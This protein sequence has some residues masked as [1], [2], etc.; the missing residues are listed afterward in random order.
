MGNMPRSTWALEISMTH[1]DNHI[2]ST[3]CSS[4]IPSASAWALS[5][6]AD[7]SCQSEEC[8][9]RSSATTSIASCT[10][11][12]ASCRQ[13]RIWHSSNVRPRLINC[14]DLELDACYWVKKN[15][16]T[17]STWT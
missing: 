17:T 15:C 8:S 13:R 3:A 6:S 12:L 4:V 7:M 5:S 10:S 2:A 14:L 11:K 1:C 16:W 9:P